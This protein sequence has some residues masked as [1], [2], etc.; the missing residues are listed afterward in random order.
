MLL[1]PQGGEKVAAIWPQGGEKVA[2]IWPM[3]SEFNCYF[4]SI[5][6]ALDA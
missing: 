1:I 6:S 5:C 3:A 2:A 4:A